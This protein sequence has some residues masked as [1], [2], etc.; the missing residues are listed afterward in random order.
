MLIP[1]PR[2]YG[3]DEIRCRICKGVGYV[4]DRQHRQTK[5]DGATCRVCGSYLEIDGKCS[6]CEVEPISV[7]LHEEVDDA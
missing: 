1:C 2:C 4:N 5:P 3:T 6:T 7:T